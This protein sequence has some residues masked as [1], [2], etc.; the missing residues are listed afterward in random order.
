MAQQKLEMG[1][2]ID[3][4]GRVQHG[5]GLEKS[6]FGSTADETKVYEDGVRRILKTEYRGRRVETTVFDSTDRP[7]FIPSD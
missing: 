6:L 5:A 7:P 2:Q 4:H 1:L 3:H